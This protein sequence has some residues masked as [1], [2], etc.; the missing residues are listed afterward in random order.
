ML[1][2]SNILFIE[3]SWPFKSSSGVFSQIRLSDSG[4][5]LYA[6]I[7][8]IMNNHTCCWTMNTCCL[9]AKMA[10]GWQNQ[11]RWIIYYVQCEEI[12]VCF[13][14]LVIHLPASK[15][16]PCLPRVPL[17]SGA[18]DTNMNVLPQVNVS[19]SPPVSL[20]F[21]HLAIHPSYHSSLS[22]HLPPLSLPP[23][24]VYTSIVFL[25]IHSPEASSSWPPSYPPP[26]PVT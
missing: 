5:H 6:N 19:Q 15:W 7:Y 3:I 25:L 16:Q 18:A 17:G 23:P 26:S 8:V 9:R 14:G 12:I 11:T 2:T 10:A 4:I 21:I 20:S 22:L 24:A 1:I 13:G